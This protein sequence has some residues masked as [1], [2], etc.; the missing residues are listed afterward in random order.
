[1]K[2]Q[3]LLVNH[4]Y[5][6]DECWCRHVYPRRGRTKTIRGEWPMQRLQKDAGH[7][8]YSSRFGEYNIISGLVLFLRFPFLLSFY[9]V[10]MDTEI[11]ALTFPPGYM[12]PWVLP[13]RG[14]S[15][16]YQKSYFSVLWSTLHFL[17][18]INPPAHIVL[19]VKAEAKSSSVVYRSNFLTTFTCHEFLQCWACL[20]AVQRAVLANRPIR[21][22]PF[23]RC[24]RIIIHIW[25]S[26][27]NHKQGHS[28]GQA[29]WIALSSADMSL[30]MRI[31][32]HSKDCMEHTLC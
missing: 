20:G 30:F 32:T 24:V 16:N 2:S 19:G 27:H 28:D 31:S 8:Q 11:Y 4:G 12:F 21:H 13:L 22:A 18:S 6:W 14:T 15:K 3:S 26:A 1:M 29:C 10:V 17:S 5:F 23:Y 9:I 25:Y 7:V